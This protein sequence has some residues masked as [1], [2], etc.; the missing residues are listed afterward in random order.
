MGNHIRV[1]LAAA[2]KRAERKRCPC[3]F[4]NPCDSRCTCANPVMSGGC[5]RCCTYGSP[6]QQQHAANIIIE[7]ESRAARYEQALDVKEPPNA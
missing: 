4:G 5:R 6:E 7:S 2:E 3:E 1:T